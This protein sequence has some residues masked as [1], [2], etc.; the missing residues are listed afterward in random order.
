ML[1][2]DITKN[3]LSFN[4]ISNCNICFKVFYGDITSSTIVSNVQVEQGLTA[5]EYEPYLGQVTKNIYL[6]EPLRKIGEVCDC[7]D[8]KEQKMI[9]K[10][11][12][13]NLSSLTFTSQP[14][15]SRWI[16]PLSNFPN[17]KV[18]DPLN[19]MAECYKV[20]SNDD[21]QTP[22]ILVYWSNSIRIKNVEDFTL[23]PMGKFYY[24]LKTPTEESVELP[25]ISTVK[26]TNILT[27][28]TIINPSDMEI[29]Y[30]K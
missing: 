19:G 27:T 22:N 12:G 6:N 7:I 2:A 20:T 14:Q 1:G 9:R 30:Y 4:V 25:K 16:C 5:T 18:A 21:A 17:I 3:T 8:Y 28:D 10:I 24:E 11:G 26:G 23:S 29:E 15:Y 13:I